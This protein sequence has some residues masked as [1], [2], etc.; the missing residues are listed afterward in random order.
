MSL[1]GTLQV[2]KSALAVQQAALQVTGNNIANA[3]NADYTRQV[4][5]LAPSRDQQIQ[6]GMF[7]GTGVDL[8]GIKRQIDEAL[9]ARLRSSISDSQA[10]DTTQQWLGRVESV[11]N[12]L[13]DQDLSTQMSTF[14]N[15][16]SN[17]ANKPQDISLRQVVLQNG[18]SL[19]GQ[20][21]SLRNQLTS[22][23][24]DVD[25]RLTGLVKNADQ[26]A[27]Q[28]A[29]LNQQIVNAEGGAGDAGGG[30]NGLRDQRDAVLKQLSNLLDVTTTEDK[31][32]I[33]V[34][35]GSEPLVIGNN[36]RGVGLKTSTDDKGR[37]T[38]EVVIKENN[39][40]LKVSSGQIGALV[41]VRGQIADTVDNIDNI[42]NNLIFELNKIHASGQGLDGYSSVT[43]AFAVK[44]PA[45]A[46][47]DPASGLK[48]TPRNGSFVVHV[49]Q[50]ATGLE[51]STLVQVDLD[52]LNGND[53]TLTSLASSID[54]IDGISA[55]VNA[56]K[57][58]VTADSNDVEVSFSQ[59]SSGVLAAVGVNNFFNG[60]DARDIAVNQAIKDQPSLLAAAKNG[61][62]GDNQTALAIAGL[63]S[64][65]IGALKGASLKETYQSVVNG[66][67]VEAATAK[68]N[69]DATKVVQDT[70]SAQRE[71]L[72]GVSL[73]EEAINL[74]RQQR[75]FQAASRVVA[76]VDEMLKT[77]ISMQ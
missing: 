68:N 48:F 61:N 25:D 15:S 45:V 72:S 32:V 29:D 16:W 67:A 42:A 28:I 49:K 34:Y 22:L 57:L 7:V 21:Q 4:A 74:M 63:E 53:T 39:G 43:S 35:V 47:N 24:G 70:L 27:S 75:A 17:L 6:P 73:D 5:T 20:F 52:G 26:L 3:G 77:L 12:E 40:T 33:N 30:A 11:F 14:F 50:K 58:N 8:T 51:T 2:G 66:V 36:S 31:G 59:D 69:A 9:N 55:G 37:L 23:Q 62:K 1:L 13:S 41:S 19:A 65:K 71:S 56:G 10:A 60:S 18:G 46:L 64:A 54:G 38:S 44:D 76:A